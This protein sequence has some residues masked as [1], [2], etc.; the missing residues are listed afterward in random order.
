MKKL[1]SLILLSAAC[2]C[3]A[4]TLP[5]KDPS[6][7]AE[8][9]AKDLLGRMTLQEKVLQIKHLHAGSIFKDQMFVPENLSEIAG[10]RSYGF[11]D[12]FPLSAQSYK[13]EMRKAQEYMVNKTRLGIPAFLVAESLH[14]V[15]QD[16]ATIFPQSIALACTFNPELAYKKAYA[17]SEE[18]KDIGVNQVFAPCIDVTR[19][20]R[21]GRLEETYGEDPYLNSVFAISEVKGYLDAG[22]SPMLKHFGPHGNPSGGLNLSTVNSSVS[23]LYD[24]YLYPFRKVVENLPIQAIMSSY[25][26]WNGCPNSASRFQMTDI[27]RGKWGYKGYVYS[28]WGAIDMLRYFHYIAPDKDSAGII[29]INAGIDAE[30]ASGCYNN[31]AKLVSEGR[32]DIKVLDR[33]VERVL[34]AK[35]RMGLFEDP[36]MDKRASGKGFHIPENVALSRAI[37]DE[38]TVLLKNDGILPLS[39]ESIKSIAVI[40]PNADQVQFGDYTWS[41]DNK[42]GVTPL[43]GLKRLSEEYGFKINYA[44][45]CTITSDDE[46]GIKAA[47]KAA[48]KSDVSII[49]AGS[50]SSSFARDGSHATSGEG[51]DTDNL[52]LSGA[53]SA[54]IKAVK[55]T[56]KPVVLVLVSGKAFSVAWEKDNINAILMQWYAGE[57]EGNSIADILFGRVNPS[58]RLTVSI[59]KS[60]GHLPAFY[61]HFPSDKGFYKKRGSKDKPGRDYVFSSPDPLW[62]FGHG[63]SYTEFEFTNP[64]VSIGND[65]VIVELD[66]RNVGKVDGMAVPQIYV[67]DIYASVPT[68]VKQLKAFK[69]VAVAAGKV[70]HVRMEIPLDELAVTGNDGIRRLEAGDFNIM[71]GHSSDNIIFTKKITVGESRIAEY[72]TVDA[73]KKVEGVGGVFVTASSAAEARGGNKKAARNSAFEEMK[74]PAAGLFPDWTNVAPGLNA[75]AVS[76]DEKFSKSIAP[77]IQARNT[78]KITGWKGERLSAQVLLWASEDIKGIEYSFQDF[79]SA[80]KSLPS[81]IAQARFV[82]YVMTD[83]YGSGCGSRKPE[84]FSA[85]LVPD[86]LDNLKSFDLEAKSVR[87]L[88]ITVDIPYY[89]TA[90]KYRGVLKIISAD[91]GHKKFNIELNV[92]DRRLPEPSQ[93]QYH[94]DLWQH[95]SAIARV[96]DLEVWSDAHFEKMRPIMKMLADAGQKVITATLNK[97][98]WNHQCFDAYEDMIRWTRNADQSWSYDYSIFDRW[99]SFMTELGV[100]KMINCYS[101][102][103][104]NNQLHYFDAEKGKMVEV[105]LKATSKEYEKI[106]SPFLKDFVRHLK[107]KGWLGITN[108]AMD[109]RAPEDMKAAL[110][111][112]KDNAPELGVAL[113]DNHRSYKEYPWIKDICVSASCRVDPEV[114]RI[115]REKGLTT[116]Y[117][118]CC[119]D[120]FPNMFTFSPSPEAVY[121]AWYAVALDLDGFLRWAYNSWVEDPLRDSRFRTWP[122]GDTYMVYPDARSSIRF[123]R[124]REGIQDAEKIRV[125]RQE[126]AKENSAASLEKLTALEAAISGFATLEPAEGWTERLNQAKS[127]LNR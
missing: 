61:N 48:K 95:P 33:A 58:G 121:S 115:R 74:D 45:G 17:T 67:R 65:K 119:A 86:M 32:L 11:I 38:S 124:L 35:F 16:G 54:L 83:E 84:D 125:L 60:V 69:K 104:W 88:W 85:A 20:P 109:E 72:G 80:G 2:I 63:L 102:L 53:Q 106:W 94:L 108:I 89:A 78:I 77:E 50:A 91:K 99:V 123:E 44:K 19:E 117:Y 5:Y 75:S 10:S 71:L 25:N 76:I 22:I 122:A 103:T 73:E 92:V 105:E 18:L 110:K 59:P 112:L 14:G 41:R 6:L 36:Y 43:Q 28:D 49:F 24:I 70:E 26:A 13:R 111:V 56:G 7:S 15:V 120:R 127:L 47:V 4:Q 34:L 107:E 62:A 126:Y 113:A 100:S 23:E 93:W 66:I 81:S 97:D 8:Q 57:Q 37:A 114:I 9:R 39:G 68:P 118:V 21:W 96:H 101:L 52:E 90:G 31:F 87:P 79:K 42:D 82:R 51:F 30:A 27:L 12:G 1:L 55:A 3:S 116:T 29:A 40:G 98:P 46:S 64:S